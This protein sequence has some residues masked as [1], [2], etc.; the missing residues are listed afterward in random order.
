MTEKRTF[1]LFT[2]L[3]ILNAFSCFRTAIIRVF[4]LDKLRSIISQSNELR[5]RMGI[6]KVDKIK[7]AGVFGTYV[8][9]EKALIMG[10]FPDCDLENVMSVGN[11][12][13]D[14]ARVVLLDR[15]MRDE[16]NWISRNVEYIELTVEKDLEQEFMESMQIPHM[17]DEF[18][19]LQGHVP[20][21]ILHQK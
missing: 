5:R 11:A 16:A 18:P 7:V 12:A 1:R 21:G 2:S 10:L 4:F 14:G 9:R 19:H 13:G 15:D 6:D 20:E 3:S 8:D 17:K